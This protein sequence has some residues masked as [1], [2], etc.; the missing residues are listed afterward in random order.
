MTRSLA[1]LPGRLARTVAVIGMLA[2]LVVPATSEPASNYGHFTLANGLE[3]YVI[4]DHRLPIVT[5][6][7]WYRVGATD[8][9]AGEAGL[10]H[11]LEHLM[12]KGTDNYPASIYNR[13][14]GTNGGVQNAFT[15]WDNT[16][17]YQRTPKDKL[18][19]LMELESDRMA[20]LKLVEA[21]VNIERGAVLE[22]L[23][24]NLNNP[25]FKMN[26]AVNEVLFAGTMYA[27]PVIGYENEIK[28]MTHANALAFYKRYYAPNNA[29]LIV[30]GDVTLDEVKTLAEATYGRLPRH[31]VVAR[32]SHTPSLKPKADRVVVEHDQVR[33]PTVS[34]RYVTPGTM[35]ISQD[36]E[37]ALVM[38]GSVLSTGQASRL[39]R[40]LVQT[41]IATSAHAG[42]STYRGIGRFS[43]DIGAAQGVSADVAEK[44]LR[45][46]IADLRAHPITQAEVDELRPLILKGRAERQDNQFGRVETLGSMLMEGRT[47]DDLIGWDDRVDRVGAAAINRVVASFLRD[48]RMVAIQLLPRL[49]AAA[50]A[51]GGAPKS[52]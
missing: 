8:E 9:K 35:G 22:E 7:V 32:V 20:H 46:F 41:R 23:R 30:A 38:L 29:V 39:H 52:N 24:R 1:R 11:F 10:A 3:G 27:R 43:F 49:A 34:I 33:T 13:F 4:Y 42:I 16:T 25:F 51:P 19:K 28:A 18:G 40:S 45:E 6:S 12:F 21:D 47:L 36:D 50:P 15:N 17:Y 48:E 26:V 14:A 2:A 5:H 31:D 37:A 44:A